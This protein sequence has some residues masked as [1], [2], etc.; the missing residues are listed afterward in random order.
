MAPYVPKKPSIHY[1]LQEHL[2]HISNQ[3]WHIRLLELAFIIPE[4]GQNKPLKNH[5]TK[6]FFLINWRLAVKDLALLHYTYSSLFN[7]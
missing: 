7:D 6:P 5:A 4:S 1:C 3:S 2:S